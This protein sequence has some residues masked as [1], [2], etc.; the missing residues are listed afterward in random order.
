MRSAFASIVLTFA[1]ITGGAGCAGGDGGDASGTLALGAAS[2]GETASPTRWQSNP[3]V[4]GNIFEFVTDA[5]APPATQPAGDGVELKQPAVIMETLD[6]SLEQFAPLWRDEIARRFPY[7]VGVLVHGGDFLEGQWIVGAHVQRG[8]HVSLATD[9][10]RRII[11]RSIP[12]G[13]SSSSPATPGTCALHVPGVYYARA[14]VWC[15]PDR[16]SDA[17]YADPFRSHAQRRLNRGEESPRSRTSRP[18]RHH[19][20]NAQGRRVR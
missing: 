12:A 9:I 6:P 1:L 14:S 19:R 2:A 11:R 20:R 10:I 13:R 8:R 18:R 4:V 15:V 17:R 3:E 16:A 7:A 5:P